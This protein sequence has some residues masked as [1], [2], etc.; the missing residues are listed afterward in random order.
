V[1][2]GAPILRHPGGRDVMS[3]G[4]VVRFPEGEGGAHQ[5]L[6]HSDEPARLVICSA[7][8][9]G[10]SASVFPDENTYVLRVP[11]Q[12]GYCFWLGD[13]LG[14]YWDGVPGAGSA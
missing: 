5:F 2:G 11:G 12:T 4:D 10:P 14:E 8:V 9:S 13:K 3:P 7:P 6:N 1:L